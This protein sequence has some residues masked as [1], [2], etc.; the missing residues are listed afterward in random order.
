LAIR[1]LENASSSLN[2]NLGFIAL[3]YLTLVFV[4]VVMWDGLR[5]SSFFLTFLDGRVASMLLAASVPRAHCMF[6]HACGA[7]QNMVVGPPGSAGSSRSQTTLSCCIVRD[8]VLSV[9]ERPEMVM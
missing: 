1:K 3:L 6:W 9:R 4:Y 8:M 5:Q 7:V 2:V